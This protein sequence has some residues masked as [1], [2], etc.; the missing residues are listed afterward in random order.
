MYQ[1][2]FKAFSQVIS[3]VSKWA[4]STIL[5]ILYLSVPNLLHKTHN[6]TVSKN[7]LRTIL[8]PI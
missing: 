3:A 5:S 4:N 2:Y 8:S 7:S 1:T 6:P